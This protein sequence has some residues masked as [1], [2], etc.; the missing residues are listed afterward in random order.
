MSNLS[1]SSVSSPKKIPAETPSVAIVTVL[2]RER[3]SPNYVGQIVKNREDYAVR[4]GY[5]NF[6]ANTS[7]YESLLNGAPR[8][9]ASVAAVR[10]AMTAHPH[11]TYFFHLSPHALI[12]NPSISLET[13]VLNS[14]RLESLIRK[15]IPVVPDTIIKTFSHVKGDDVDL[16]IAQD[17]EDLS[18]GSF[19]LK[20][21]D[22][23]RFFLDLWFDPLYRSY[24]FVKAETH[25]L[26]H[27]VQWHPTILAKLAIVPQRILNAYPKDS[28][29]A[30]INGTYEEGDFLIRFLGCDDGDMQLC[31]EMA[32]YYS[33][34]T[35][36]ISAGSRTG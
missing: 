35:K 7:D 20:R 18:T 10:H 1:S 16:V 15:D 36:K 5:T 12:M 29:A 3:L 6:F 32:P 8:S 4:H 19:I 23:A 9:W 31:E 17:R 11:S 30:G 22:F 25:A 33:T 14:K 26:D 2:D 21:G 34:W 13:H 27:I 24:A 28:P